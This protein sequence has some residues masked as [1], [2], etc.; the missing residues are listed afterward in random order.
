MRN[1]L[2]ILL[3]TAALAGPSAVL[4][5]TSAKGDGT[6][7][8]KDANGMVTLSARGIVFGRIEN[9]WIRIVDYRPDDENTFEDFGTCAI[10]RFPDDQTT[11]CRGTS[12]RFRFAAGKFDLRLG[13]RR[14]NVTAVGKG[15][16][17]IDAAD[18][19]IDPWTYSV[20]GGPFESL[21]FVPAS[22]TLGLPAP[23]GG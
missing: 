17:T 4:A 15:T 1:A 20:N 22:F 5:G 3:V 10:T 19:A 7:S 21:P 11:V 8:V 2:L 18:T 14:V 16:G 6:L 23:A 12:L 13:G 9:G